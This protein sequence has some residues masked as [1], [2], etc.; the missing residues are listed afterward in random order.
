MKERSMIAGNGPRPGE[1]A[2]SGGER[3]GMAARARKVAIATARQLGAAVIGAVLVLA[4]L[5]GTATAAE[6]KGDGRQTNHR[7]IDEA[8][9]ISGY[10]NA[11]IDEGCYKTL[12][13]IAHLGTNINRYIPALRDHRGTLSL[14]LE[15]QFNPVLKPSAV[16]FGLGIGLQYAYPLTERFSPYFLLAT[17]LHYISVDTT[18]Q[19]DGFNFSDLAGIGFY[20]ALSKGVALNCGYR[21]RHVS[22]ADLKKPNSG[23]NS[24]IG[25]LGVSFFF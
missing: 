10:G 14:F 3:S 20:L 13:M 15:P 1:G 18:T 17:G 8:G 22:N 19:A 16:E 25:V 21:Y 6:E 24:H 11:S 9:F 4:P 12:F 7:W 5:S 23:I 2:A